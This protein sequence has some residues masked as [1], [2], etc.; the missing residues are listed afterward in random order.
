MNPLIQWFPPKPKAD[1]VNLRRI[2]VDINLYDV[3]NLES[4][5]HVQWYI[6]EK[7]REAGIPVSPLAG[8]L[9]H[10]VLTYFELNDCCKRRY[11]WE[12]A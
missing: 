1:P 6:L 3:M 2:V 8:D 7:L 9:H 11:V 10:G 5:A 4:D 12:G